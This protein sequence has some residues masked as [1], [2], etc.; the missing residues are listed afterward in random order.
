[1]LRIMMVNSEIPETSGDNGSNGEESDST[2]SSYRVKISDSEEDTKGED[3]D[4]LEDLSDLLEE[5]ERA[6]SI[7]TWR[8]SR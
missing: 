8:D 1:M 2:E 3:D 6:K 4:E 7:R 5:E